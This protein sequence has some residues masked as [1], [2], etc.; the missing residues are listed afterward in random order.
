MRGWSF[1][2]HGMQG[3]RNADMNFSALSADAFIM[4]TIIF[5]IKKLQSQMRVINA[6]VAACAM[7]PL[8]V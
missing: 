3:R 4:Q 5:S 8:T 7:G 6:N 2:E 1:L